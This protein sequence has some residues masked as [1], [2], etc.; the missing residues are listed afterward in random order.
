MQHIDSVLQG[1]S[2]TSAE[3]TLAPVGD[4]GG[5]CSGGHVAAR[6]SASSGLMSIRLQPQSRRQ[7]MKVPH[8]WSAVRTDCL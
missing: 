8:Y 5:R 3:Q 6:S 1:M 2:S 7:I 4:P